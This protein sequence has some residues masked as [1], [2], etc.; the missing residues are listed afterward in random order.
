MTETLKISVPPY[1]HTDKAEPAC[2]FCANFLWQRE[3]PTGIYRE[4]AYLTPLEQLI[5]TVRTLRLHKRKEG[6]AIL[7]G[8]L[9]VIFRGCGRCVCISGKRATPFFR[10]TWLSYSV[11]GKSPK[12]SCTPSSPLM[13][14]IGLARATGLFSRT[15]CGNRSTDCKTGISF[16][17]CAYTS[18]RPPTPSAPTHSMSGAN[19]RGKAPFPFQNRPSGFRLRADGFGGFDAAVRHIAFSLCRKSLRPPLAKAES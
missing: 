2:L 9:V 5:D 13:G 18:T 4:H 6:D 3:R 15:S 1:P 12:T 17:P 10:A 8:D 11:E 19:S 7:P 14:T 16:P